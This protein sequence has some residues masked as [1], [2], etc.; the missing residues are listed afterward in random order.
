MSSSSGE[1]SPSRRTLF[2]SRCRKLTLTGIHLGGDD[3]LTEVEFF[4]Q[5][6]SH[7]PGYERAD[8]PAESCYFLYDAGTQ[9]GVGLLGHHKYRF[10][11]FVEFSVHQCKLEFEFKIRNSPQT[12]NDHAALLLFDIV[13]E[14]PA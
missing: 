4:A 13:H 11:P 3:R 8:I 9:E 7:V 1:S 5:R 10:D 2:S 14:Q 12:T 6:L